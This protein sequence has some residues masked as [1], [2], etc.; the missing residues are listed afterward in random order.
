MRI[1]LSRLGRGLLAGLLV[2]ALSATSALAQVDTGTIL[3]TVK[4]QSGAIV[5]GATVTITHSNV[6]F[7]FLCVLARLR[8][9]MVA[10][11]MIHYDVQLIGGTVCI[12]GK[13]PRWLQV[14]VK[15]SLLRCLYLNA[16]AGRGVHVVTV[17]DYLSRRDS[18]WNGPIF[19]FLG[20]TVDCID[21]HEPNSPERISIQGRHNIRYQ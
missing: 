15:R 14:K 2:Q 1:L 3:G 6:F 13:F 9:A 10:W 8:I 18:E 17:N 19:E 5:P 12:R 7:F 20:L 11:N 21:K 4:D 16:L